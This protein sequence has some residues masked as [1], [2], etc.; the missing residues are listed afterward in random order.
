MLKIGIIG[1]GEIATK[2][3]LPVIGRKNLDVHLCSRNSKNLLSLGDQYRFKNRHSSLDSLINA[4]IK[5]AFVHTATGSHFE[6]VKKLLD[7]NIHV[8]VDKPVTY[9]YETTQVLVG[10]A[11]K[12]NLT[13]MAGFNRRYAPA[14]VKLKELKNPNMIIMQKNRRSLPGDVRT[15]V[16]DD[17][18]HVLDSLLFLFP[19]PIENLTVTG[20]KTGG[21]LYHVVVQFTSADGTTA[22]GIMNRDS[23]TVEEK[24][25]VFTPEEKWVVND[26]TETVILRDKNAIRQGINHW[27][28]TLYKRG[29]DQITESFLQSVTKNASPV[30][31]HQDLL[32]THQLCERVVGELA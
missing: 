24:L 10:L 12:K 25:E 1:L 29:F 16:F 31:L 3:Y 28:S 32:I 18:I 9:D 14:Y 27:E 21:L 23:G 17:F 4:G 8:Y 6:I 22:I 20:R 13:L 19:D 11:N 30:Q 2:A 26:L 7:N 15:F 5:A